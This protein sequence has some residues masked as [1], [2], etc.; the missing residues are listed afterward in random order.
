M[1]HFTRNNNNTQLFKLNTYQVCIICDADESKPKL[2]T[3]FS[4]LRRD[5]I[6]TAAHVVINHGLPRE[7][8]YGI[9]SNAIIKVQLKV[10]AIHKESDLAVLQI[11]SQL[12]PCTLPLYPG[13]EDMSTSKGLVNCGFVP[14]RNALVMNLV[15]SFSRY[16]REREKT[17]TVLEFDGTNIEGGSSGGPIFG[18]GGVVLGVMTNLFPLEDQPNKKFARAVS[19][20]SLMDAITMNFDTETFEVL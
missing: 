17:E 9:F 13:Y 18:D 16:D 12:N 8:L 10:I 11:T 19:I 7:N 3:G 4:F 2:G 5:W 14:S 15:R 1:E 20:R 6:V